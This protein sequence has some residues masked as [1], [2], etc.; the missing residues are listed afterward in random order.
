MFGMDTGQII[1]IAFLFVLALS[2]L[3]SIWSHKETLR[4]AL[5]WIVIFAGVAFGSGALDQAHFGFA[6][7]EPTFT[8]ATIEVPKGRDNPFYFDRVVKSPIRDFSLHGKGKAWFSLSSQ[9]NDIRCESLIWA[10]RTGR[11]DDFLRSHQLSACYFP[12][13][14]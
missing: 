10:P 7:P 1:G 12:L 8:G 9:I 14:R 11:V 2:L 3:G 4:N 13:H 5:I 6:Q